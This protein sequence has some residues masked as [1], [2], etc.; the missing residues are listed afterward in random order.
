M[1]IR[2]AGRAV[3]R[4]D[5]EITKVERLYTLDHQVPAPVESAVSDVP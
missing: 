3:R 2:E 1:T 5:P 4:G